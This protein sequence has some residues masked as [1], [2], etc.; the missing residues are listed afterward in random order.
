MSEII[1]I[2]DRT[3]GKFTYS[4]MKKK[5]PLN[6]TISKPNVVEENS[7]QSPDQLSNE[8]ENTTAIAS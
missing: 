8:K 2:P 3:A 4:E 5:L 1:G 6:A 7:K